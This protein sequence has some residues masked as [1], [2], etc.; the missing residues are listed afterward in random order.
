M[1]NTFFELYNEN[2]VYKQWDNKLTNAKVLAADNLNNLRDK[3]NAKEDLITIV[4]NF[5][6]YEPFRLPGTKPSQNTDDDPNAFRFVYY[7]PFYRVKVAFLT[8]LNKN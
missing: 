3:V 1:E 8:P 7:D 6:E 4:N 2:F 5:N